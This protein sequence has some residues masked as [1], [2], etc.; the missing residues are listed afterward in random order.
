MGAHPNIGIDKWPQQ[1][2]E[3]GQRAE[4]I[5]HYDTSR[6]LMGTIVRDDSEEPFET[7]IRLDSG[8]IVRGSECQYA[9]VRR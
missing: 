5:F 7:M 4:V 9:P 3:L 2:S 1:G 6:V 8:Q